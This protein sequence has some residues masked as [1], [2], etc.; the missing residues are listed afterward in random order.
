ME[1]WQLDV[2]GGVL[3][4]DGTDLKAVTA[5]DDH[6]RLC[7]VVGLME[8]ATSRPMEV[9]FDR[10][11]RENGIRHLLTAPRSPSTDGCRSLPPFTAA[12]ARS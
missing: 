7:L 4:E 6:S 2:M 1:L 11:C 3:L 9:L 12:C 10:I 8:R 5:I